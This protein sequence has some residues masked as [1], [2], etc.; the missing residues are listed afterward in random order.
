MTHYSGP[1]DSAE[2]LRWAA[3][4]YHQAVARGGCYEPEPDWNVEVISPR[5]RA[6]ATEIERLRA[7][8]AVMEKA[9]RQIQT[10]PHPSVA[11]QCAGCY[12][13]QQTATYARKDAK[14]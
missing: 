13:H 4:I 5:L 10:R 14:P 12:G 9:L 8:V 6:A 1:E 11:A 7:R 3:D 2:W